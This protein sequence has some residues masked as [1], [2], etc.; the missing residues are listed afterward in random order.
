MSVT[1]LAAGLADEV[2]VTRPRQPADSPAGGR[3]EC[4]GVPADGSGG[5]GDQQRPAGRLAQDRECLRC[6][7]R[8]ERHRGGLDGVEPV[9]QR[10]HRAR[11]QHHALGVGATGSAEVGV[12]VGDDVADSEIAD[13]GAD[14]GDPAD[15]VPPETDPRL[16]AEALV[17]EPTA[18]KWSMGL[19]PAAMTS[20]ATWPAP[21]VGAARSMTCASVVSGWETT[22]RMVLLLLVAVTS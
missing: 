16:Q 12:E 3:G 17:V 19:T 13:A 21:A 6:G 22:A 14:L 5:A 18:T 1:S 15:H 8:V 9:R 4:H 20:M 2:P 11:G 10:G 7:E